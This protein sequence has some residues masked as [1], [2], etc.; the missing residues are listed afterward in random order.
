MT[1][2]AATVTAWPAAASPLTAGLLAHPG[3]LV[4]LGVFPTAVYLGGH[5]HHR[6]LPLLA[7]DAL[8]LPTGLRV[9]EPSYRVDWGLGP[10]DEVEVDAGGL[11]WPGRHVR[12]A[13]QWRPATVPGPAVPVP[14]ETLRPVAAEL[15]GAASSHA[16]LGRARSLTAAVVTDAPLEERVLGLVGLGA[17]L[18]PAGDDALCGV[19]LT[20]RATG[21][22]RGAER[23]AAAVRAA[24]H[25][26]TSIS[27][28]LLDA[29]AQ[30]FATPAVTGLVVAVA[31][32]DRDAVRALVPAVLAMGHSSG[33]DVAAGVAGA[34]LALAEAPRAEPPRDA[35]TGDTDRKVDQ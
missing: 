12:A 16:L 29:A 4:V 7:A 33:A 3:S 26:T 23:L 10:G 34:A 35:P 17:G 5:E 2:A 24:L 19:L 20:L 6:V 18:T 9:A 11:R 27:A 31:R 1:A 30:G 21:R 25:R 22:T 15:S 14:G 28:S 13:R 8:L 32:G